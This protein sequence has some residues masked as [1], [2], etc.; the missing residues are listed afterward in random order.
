M[1]SLEREQLSRQLEGE[2]R[3]IVQENRFLIGMKPAVKNLLMGVC[4]L[5]DWQI[6]KKDL[7]KL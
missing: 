4:V 7:E 5:N 6:L 3:Q 2:A 1:N